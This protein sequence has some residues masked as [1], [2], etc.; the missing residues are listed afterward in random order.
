M[1]EVVYILTMGSW[2]RFVCVSALSVEMN[3]QRQ[4]GVLLPVTQGGQA[5]GLERGQSQP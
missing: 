1:V 5:V 4:G 3:W 2:E